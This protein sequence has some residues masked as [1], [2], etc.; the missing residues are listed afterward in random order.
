MFIST[1][2]NG[3]MLHHEGPSTSSISE[4]QKKTDSNSLGHVVDFGMNSFDCVNYNSLNHLNY[5]QS[6]RGFPFQ[7]AICNKLK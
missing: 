5:A 2:V 1:I 6:L 3:N 4:K 7:T